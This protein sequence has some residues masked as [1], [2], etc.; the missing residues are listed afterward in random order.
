MTTHIPAWITTVID[1]LAEHDATG[2]PLARIADRIVRL[3]RLGGNERRLAR[4]V[5]FDFLRRKQGLMQDIEKV[6]KTVGGLKPSLRDKLLVAVLMADAHARESVPKDAIAPQ[7]RELLIQQASVEADSLPAWLAGRL[8]VAYKDDAP[9]LMV[10]LLQ[11]ALPNLAVDRKSLSLAEALKLLRESGVECE[12]SHVYPDAI[13]VISPEFSFSGLP[14]TLQKSL[15]LM[16]EASQLVASHVEAKP[17]QTVLDMCA[18]GGGKSRFILQTDAQVIAMDRSLARIKAALKRPGMKAI[19]HV[20]ADGLMPPF[21]QKSF[22][23]VIVDAPCSGTGVIRREP[24]RV[25]RL[26]AEE[27]KELSLLQAKLLRSAASLVKPGGKLIYVTCSILPEENQD[28]V[29]VFLKDN[30]TMVLDFERQL[31]PSREGCDGFFVASITR[32]QQL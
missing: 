30:P 21:A 25:W 18:G 14:K 3:R 31:L 20:I 12:S 11:R 27:V 15:W 2:Q 4:D 24:D 10:S 17:G 7:F 23:W 26:T 19:E 16:D 29:S 22:D 28:I 13:R 5:V 8:E 1:I 6:C 32:H 9:A